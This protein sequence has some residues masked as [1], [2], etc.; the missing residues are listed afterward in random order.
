MQKTIKQ[1]YLFN[2]STSNFGITAAVYGDEMS[3]VYDN[4]S[5]WP[6]CKQM[7]R[8]VSERDFRTSKMSGIFIQIWKYKWLMLGIL[9][10]KHTKKLV[11]ANYLPINFIFNIPID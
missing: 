2:W 1:W 4:I 11:H 7:A 9:Q 8:N 6:F 3:I 5:L 10:K